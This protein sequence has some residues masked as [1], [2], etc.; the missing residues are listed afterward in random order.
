MIKKR[1]VLFLFPSI[2]LTQFVTFLAN[3]G[4]WYHY[5]AHFHVFMQHFSDAEV[6]AAQEDMFSRCYTS[7]FLCCF[8]HS[9][10]VFLTNSRFKQALMEMQTH[11]NLKS[12]PWQLSTWPWWVQKDP[13]VRRYRSARHQAAPASEQSSACTQTA[14]CGLS[15]YPLCLCHMVKQLT[16]F[17]HHNKTQG[18]FQMAKWK[19][20][21]GFRFQLYAN[22]AILTILN[23]CKSQTEDICLITEEIG[24]WL[25]FTSSFFCNLNC[26]E[27]M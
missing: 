24:K 6:C 17:P 1:S 13:P 11:S 10:D 23:Q 4:L 18:S 27:F 22:C 15:C 3:R 7:E 14:G 19:L 12:F 2:F 9:Y 16:L 25:C 8:W 5:I 20:S 21:A 26:S